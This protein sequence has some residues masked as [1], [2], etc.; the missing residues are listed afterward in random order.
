MALKMYRL[1]DGKR[2]GFAVPSA[3]SDSP[4]ASL[5]WHDA[6][7]DFTTDEKRVTL[8]ALQSFIQQQVGTALVTVNIWAP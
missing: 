5:V 7:A 8:D 4:N 6:W 2:I 3:C 1:A